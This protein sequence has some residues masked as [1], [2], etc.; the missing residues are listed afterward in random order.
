MTIL[1]T[2]LSALVAALFLVSSPSAHAFELKP[3]VA[4]HP[5]M[6][7]GD[8]DANYFVQLSELGNALFFDPPAGVTYTV[9][10]PVADVLSH[11]KAT[12]FANQGL[13]NVI[14]E[15]SGGATFNGIPNRIALH[16]DEKIG[17]V[18]DEVS[19]IWRTWSRNRA[20]SV[21]QTHVASISVAN[22]NTLTWQALGPAFSQLHLLQSPYS[23]I[24]I[25]VDLHVGGSPGDW[26]LITLLK[27][28][29]PVHS[30][31]TDALAAVK[32]TDP[33]ALYPVHLQYEDAGGVAYPSLD[34]PIFQVVWKTIA[35]GSIW[36]GRPAASAWPRVN[37]SIISKEI[38]L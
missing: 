18:A 36:H 23:R 16:L 24:T 7:G 8:Q 37:G 5:G 35:S 6:P 38:A 31:E 11:N 32:V 29:Q 34:Q 3:V 2:I 13:G 12:L 20:N 27:N 19:N 9:I 14:L 25:S 21:A 17:L 10:M 33:F 22:T 28:G 1:R 26:V 4:L 15:S 30:Q